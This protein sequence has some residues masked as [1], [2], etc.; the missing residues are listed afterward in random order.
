MNYNHGAP[1]YKLVGGV[2]IVRGPNKGDVEF[3]KFTQSGL[4]YGTALIFQR[5]YGGKIRGKRRRN[6]MR[7]K[8]NL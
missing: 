6:G 5:V 1:I 7:R 2:Q 3:V 8:R 4:C